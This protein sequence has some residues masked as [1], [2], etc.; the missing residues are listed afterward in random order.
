MAIQRGGQQA[1]ETVFSVGLNV[2][3]TGSK[4]MSQGQQ[5]EAM[6]GLSSARIIIVDGGANVIINPSAKVL[7]D[8]VVPAQE[9]KTGSVG[10]GLHTKGLKF[11][12]A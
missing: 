9:F 4:E 5:D 12:R 1:Q 8:E 3:L 2:I 6:E 10:F 11:E 7:V